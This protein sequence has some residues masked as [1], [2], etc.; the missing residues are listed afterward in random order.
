MK[1]LVKML[2]VFSTLYAVG[3]LMRRNRVGWPFAFVGT[4]VVSLLGTAGDRML[5][6]KMT[7]L[8]A[9]LTD[10]LLIAGSLFSARKMVPGDR[11]TAISLPYIGIVTAVLGAFE[12]LY[13]EWVFPRKKYQEQVVEEKGV[14]VH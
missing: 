12:S 8:T 5:M 13:H 1:L 14:W 6:P 9:V 7:R 3:A 10:L 2:V 4:A 11:S